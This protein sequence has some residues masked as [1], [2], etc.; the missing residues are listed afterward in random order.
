MNQVHCERQRNVQNRTPIGQV[1]FS[2]CGAQVNTGRS[3]TP[4]TDALFGYF[5]FFSD[6][7]FDSPVIQGGPAGTALNGANGDDA[8]FF[9]TQWTVNF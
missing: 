9:Y 3:I 5:H 2:D 1:S 7:Y 6:N 4:R 8:D